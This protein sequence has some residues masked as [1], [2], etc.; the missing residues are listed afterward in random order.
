MS[1]DLN[2]RAPVERSQNSICEKEPIKSERS[3]A[4]IQ[5]S[6]VYEAHCG[7]QSCDR[8]AGVPIYLART[9]YQFLV[10]G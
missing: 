2:P 8:N 1:P 7:L 10:V 5:N 3:G 4:V 6:K 9:V